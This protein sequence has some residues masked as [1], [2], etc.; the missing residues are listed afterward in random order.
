MY[1]PQQQQY[2][3]QPYG[4]GY[5]QQGMPNIQMMP[6]QQYA[7]VAIQNGLQ[8]LASAQGIFIE[9]K[10]EVIEALTGC[11][12]PNV[13]KVYPADVN[14]IQTSD[15]TIFKCKELSNCC[16]R[17]CIA[18]SCRP[19]D[20]AVTNQ[21]GK[22][23]Y[24]QLSGSTFIQ[25]QR[26][27]KC[28]CLCFNRPELSVTVVE[29]GMNQYLGKIREP[30]R[31]CD[32]CVEIEDAAGNLKFIISGS[33]C[34]LGYLCM[35]C[36]YQSCQELTFEVKNPAGELITRIL[37]KSAGCLKSCFG[38]TDNF[39]IGFPP[40]LSPEDKALFMAATLLIDYMYF[41]NKTEQPNDL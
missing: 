13:Y 23:N 3:Q 35:G 30:F 10:L 5:G 6:M 12:T 8:K 36:P 20:M 29:N 22:L 1:P 25:M 26:P 15:Q 7:V 39:T 14:G 27:F 37:K 4:Q 28:T 16:V 2:N 17:Q 24:G 41:E 34:Q 32:L 11:Q 31:F 40:G 33:C 21:Q 38:K 9:Q 18:P 19:F